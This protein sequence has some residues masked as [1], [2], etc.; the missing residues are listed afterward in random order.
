MFFLLTTF[1]I[2]SSIGFILRNP[3]C[4][5]VANYTR[6]E[7][8]KHFSTDNLKNTTTVMATS[9]ESCSNLCTL[10]PSCLFFN[11]NIALE[12]CGLIHSHIGSLQN[13]PDWIF[14][15]T[16][17]TEF[18]YRG[19][20]CQQLRPAFDYNQVCVDTCTSYRIE[21]LENIALKKRTRSSSVSS[22]DFNSRNA[23][24]GSH[25]GYKL[26]GKLFHTKRSNREWLFI[27]FGK[28]YK[29]LFLAFY[30]RIDVLVA[31]RRS[32]QITIRIGS[33]E[34]EDEINSNDLCASNKDFSDDDVAIFFCEHG[35]IFGRY[36]YLVQERD[37]AGT[38]PINFRELEVFSY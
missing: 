12:K 18:K 23:V 8:G 16:D 32:R 9:T 26:G 2:E 24:D 13:R 1:L 22:D 4:R 36:L 5:Y 35:D 15:S 17:Y 34:S 33:H 30:N 14:A 6:L 19:Q 10:S 3:E 20:R 31:K 25:V 21:K 28:E 38:D 11:H 27:D 37:G 29:I 7:S